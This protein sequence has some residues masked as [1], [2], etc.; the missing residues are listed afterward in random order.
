[1]DTEGDTS[2]LRL[3]SEDKLEWW[4]NEVMEIPACSVLKYVHPAR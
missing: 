3:S 2:M 1:M 4:A